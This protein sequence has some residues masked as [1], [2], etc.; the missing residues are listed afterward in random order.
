[1]EVRK[2]LGGAL[3]MKKI[4]QQEELVFVYGTLRKHE[5]NYPLISSAELISEQC[6]TKGKLYDTERDYPAL[7]QSDEGRT[8]GELYRVSAQLLMALNELEGYVGEGQKNDYE[9]VTQKVYSDQGSVQALVYVYQS[10]QVKQLSCIACGDWKLYRMNPEQP[11][12]YFAYGSCMHH[13][14]M[15]KAGVYELFQLI[16]KGVCPGYSLQFTHHSTDGGKADMVERGKIDGTD[17]IDR[18]DDKRAG[19]VE[20]KMY[21]I[22]KQALSYLYEREGVHHGI[23][24]PTFIDIESEGQVLPNVLTFMV[25]NKKE[26]IAPT[27]KYAEEIVHGGQEVLS[28]TYLSQLCQDLDNKFGMLIF[29]KNKY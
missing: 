14:R 19:E 3:I 25:I 24:R 11:A 13:E 23:Y 17:E 22:D 4:E 18:V 6:W 27:R 16:G 2:G 29:F 21:R 9:R 8:Y 10:D 20:G 15:Q 12:L 28:T 26:E 5:R 1:M 7:V